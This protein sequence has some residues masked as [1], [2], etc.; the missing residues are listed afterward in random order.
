MDEARNIL[1]SYGSQVIIFCQLKSIISGLNDYTCYDRIKT[2]SWR[3]LKLKFYLSLL[4]QE[5]TIRFEFWYWLVFQVIDIILARDSDNQPTPP[6]NSSII[7]QGTSIPGLFRQI[8]KSW[9]SNFSQIFFSKFSGP[10]PVERRRRRKLPLIE[11]PRSAPVHGSPESQHRSINSNS[12]CQNCSTPGRHRNY[13]EGSVC[14]GSVHNLQLRDQ[15]DDRPQV[16]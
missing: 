11:R 13:R 15:D 12:S 14:G 7:P 16:I 2:I 9:L 5:F 10:T 1:S 3:I 8:R 6:N 4:P